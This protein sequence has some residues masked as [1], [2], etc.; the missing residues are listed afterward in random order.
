MIESL[1]LS[2]K[3]FYNTRFQK[4]HQKLY[5]FLN[6]NTRIYEWYYGEFPKRPANFFSENTSLEINANSQILKTETTISGLTFQYE[7]LSAAIDPKRES[8]QISRIV[9]IRISNS[10]RVVSKIFTYHQLLS[11]FDQYL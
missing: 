1:K 4:L 10:L 6:S 11:P 9:K 5:Y 3:I 2:T 7:T 8:D